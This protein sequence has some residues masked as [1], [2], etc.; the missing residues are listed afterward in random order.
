MYVYHWGN[1][2]CDHHSANRPQCPFR[3]PRGHRIWMR[4]HA[5]QCKWAWCLTFYKVRHVELQAEE[6]TVDGLHEISHF[7]SRVAWSSQSPQS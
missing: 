5:I 2:G 3:W 1:Q 7:I 6:H 4:G